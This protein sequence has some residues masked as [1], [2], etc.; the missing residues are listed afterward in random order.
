[1]KALY[2]LILRARQKP[3]TVTYDLIYDGGGSTWEQ[4]YR[5]K[6]TAHMCIWLNKYIFSW[7]G[8]AELRRS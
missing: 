3:F 5:T 6:A 7:G 2:L 4:S 1:M 8:T